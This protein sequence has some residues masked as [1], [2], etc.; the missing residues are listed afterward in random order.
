MNFQNNFTNENPNILF[1]KILNASKEVEIPD[2][3]VL[4]NGENR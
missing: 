4:E 2:A 1:S 3:P